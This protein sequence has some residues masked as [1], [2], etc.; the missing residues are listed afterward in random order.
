MHRPT[1][2]QPLVWLTNIFSCYCSEIGRPLLLKGHQNLED[3]RF[4]TCAFS[5]AKLAMVISSNLGL[6]DEM[7]QIITNT[8][9]TAFRCKWRL[10]FFWFYVLERYELWLFLI[11]ANGRWGEWSDW[12]DCNAE[13]QSIRVRSCDSP[14]PANGGRDCRSGAALEKKNCTGGLCAGKL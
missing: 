11:A 12:Y 13:C 4:V 8:Q 1:C 5:N 10:Y 3:P 14:S 7:K 2:M 9:K 6:W